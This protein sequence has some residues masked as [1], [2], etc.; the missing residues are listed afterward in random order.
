MGTHS[1]YRDTA[2]VADVLQWMNTGIIEVV[3]DVIYKNHKNGDRCE[4][5]RRR[6][7]RKGM[8]D[9]DWRVDLAV[10]KVRRSMM[11]SQVVWMWNTRCEIPKDFEIHHIDENFDNNAFS[12]LICVHMIDHQKFHQMDGVGDEETPF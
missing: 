7:K 8:S 5:S 9:G 6:T 12:N 10:G 2:R 1:Y 3:G 11:V 4:L